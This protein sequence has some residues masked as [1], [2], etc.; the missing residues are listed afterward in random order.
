[1]LRKTV[2]AIGVAALYGAG[3]SIALPA[4]AAGPDGPGVV[5]IAQ[6]APKKACNPCNPCAAKNPCNPCNPCAVK[7][8]KLKVCNPCNP[9]N[10]CAAKNP[11]NPCNPCAAKKTN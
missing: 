11:C 5:Q 6:C 10:P 2:A 7:K 9:C 8:I 4:A 3:A 1:M